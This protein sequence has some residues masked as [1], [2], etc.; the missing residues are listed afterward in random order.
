MQ[1]PGLLAVSIADACKVTGLC[2]T[3]IYEHIKSGRLCAR[4]VGRR[5]VILAGDLRAWLENMPTI[6][7]A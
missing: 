5:T 1:D 6:K 7:A 2:R 4:K 3:V